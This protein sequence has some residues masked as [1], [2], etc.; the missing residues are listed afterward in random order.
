MRLYGLLGSQR[1]A[2]WS[3]IVGGR[4]KDEVYLSTRAE[5]G[6]LKISLHSSGY[7]Q[8]GFTPR[9][10]EQLPAG[11]REA[12]DKWKRRRGDAGERVLAYRIVLPGQSMRLALGSQ[13]PEAVPIPLSGNDRELT[14][15]LQFTEP[16][17]TPLTPWPD[18]PLVASYELGRG[19]VLE[20]TARERPTDPGLMAAYVNAKRQFPATMLPGSLYASSPGYGFGW[21]PRPGVRCATELP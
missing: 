1:S 7:S 12:L 14:I 16:P 9:V 5:L 20:L 18:G 2:E 4:S 13:H 21:D 8:H 19:T 15:D 6:D 17:A 10:R 3:V 11:N